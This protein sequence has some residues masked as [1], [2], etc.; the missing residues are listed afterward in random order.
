M[1]IIGIFELKKVISKEK[2]EIIINEK[3]IMSNGLIQIKVKD[4]EFNLL[5][6][7]YEKASN[8]VLEMINGVKLEYENMFQKSIINHTI[9]R[10][11]EPKSILNKMKKKSLELN[12]KSLVNNIND[13]AGVRI[14]C[15]E[16][17]DIYTIANIIEK[18][19]NWNLISVKDYIK[20]PKKSGYSGYHMIVEVPVRIE[21]EKYLSSQIFVKVEIQIRTMA[22]DFWATNEH[23]MKYKSSQKL[24]FWDSKRL[25]MYA[26]II[27][28]IENR[29][30]KIRSRVQI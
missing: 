21:E 15:P 14:V 20:N 24:S 4:K 6:G 30:T 7:I 28:E 17:E 13:V 9:S 27:N 5:M 2:N 26:K 8:K 12:Y 10:I 19:P 29:F 11:K 16:K 1:I 22:M 18:I 25:V 3:G 23:K